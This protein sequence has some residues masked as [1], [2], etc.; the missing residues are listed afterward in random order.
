M[1]K[2]TPAQTALLLLG[3]LVLLGGVVCV[4]LGFTG[5]ADSSNDLGSD[6]DVHSMALF[7]GGGLAAVVGFGIIAFTRASIMTRN[8]GY[9]RITVEQGVAPS[10]GGRFCSSCGRAMSSTARFCDSCGAALV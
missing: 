6:S 2:R 8:G 3:A 7:A 5:F 10:G 1:S 4:V 9:A